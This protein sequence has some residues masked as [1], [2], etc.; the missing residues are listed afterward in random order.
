MPLPPGSLPLVLPPLPLPCACSA[1]HHGSLTMTA[2]ALMTCSD[3]PS[4][5]HLL[6][7]QGRPLKGLTSQLPPP[8]RPPLIPPRNHPLRLPPPLTPRLAAI[9]A[10][11]PSGHRNGLPRAPLRLRQTHRRHS[12]RELSSSG[13]R[14]PALAPLPRAKCRSDP[15][16]CLPNPRRQGK[17]VRHGWGRRQVRLPMATLASAANT[18]QATSAAACSSPLSAPCHWAWTS[19]TS[20]R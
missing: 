19:L 4:L 13:V 9:G 10:G 16:R 11:R 2:A 20:F 5:P 14:R 17:A 1:H 15:P 8:A 3:P 18:T 7:H 12:R 6:S